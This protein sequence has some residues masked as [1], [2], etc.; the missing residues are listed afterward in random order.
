MFPMLNIEEYVSSAAPSQPS[1]DLRPPQLKL[2]NINA[3]I[4][5]LLEKRGMGCYFD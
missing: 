2:V 3:S 4:T 5:D 1:L